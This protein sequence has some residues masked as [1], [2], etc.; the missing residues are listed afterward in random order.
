VKCKKKRQSVGSANRFIHTLLVGTTLEKPGL[1][2]KD[3]DIKM[4]N[5]TPKKAINGLSKQKSL[6]S[7]G[8]DGNL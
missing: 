7:G 1:V 4:L 8:S 2:K 3:K 5:A 6:A